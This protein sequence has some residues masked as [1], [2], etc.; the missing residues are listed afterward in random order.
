MGSLSLLNHRFRGRRFL[1]IVEM[2]GVGADRQFLDL[3]QACN[4][5]G[6]ERVAKHPIRVE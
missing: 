3:R 6:W 1:Q 5:V 2:L 4:F